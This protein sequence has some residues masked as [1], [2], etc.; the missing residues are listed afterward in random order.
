[1][2]K[3]RKQSYYFRSTKEISTPDWISVFAKII[4]GAMIF[5]ILLLTITPWQQT[6]QGTGRLIALNPN[7]RVQT[8]SSNVPGRIKRWLVTDGSQVK[9]GDPL[10]EIVDNDPLFLQRL[11]TERDAI[12]KKYEA[13][14]S[15]AETALL[16]YQR[17]EKLFKQGLSSRA[18]YEKAKIEYKKLLANEAVASANL[19]QAESNLSR[20]Q[21]QLVTAPRDGTILRVLHGSGAVFVKEGD[22]IASFVPANIQPAVEI[23]I[24]GNDLPLVYPGRHVRLQFEGWPA[25]QFSGWPSVA[26]GTF[27]G[28]V[29]VVDPSASSNGKFRVI[30]TAEEGDDWPDQTFLRQGTRAYGWILLNEVKLGYELWRQFNG[31]P[32]S[33]DM[34]PEDSINGNDKKGTSSKKKKAK[35][36]KPIYG[37]K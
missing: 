29:T 35:P 7:D 26:V 14:K 19:A 5:I 37:D 11:R 21:S 34:A 25:V 28:V 16:N 13:A 24:N 32:P 22:S 12:F 15:A 1:M 30:V 6:S 36:Y 3:L 31:F 10:V 18:K 4:T 17:Q 9:E 33:I 23:Y 2:S 20:Q 8:I 27:G